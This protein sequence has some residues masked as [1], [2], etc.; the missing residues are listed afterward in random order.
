MRTTYDASTGQLWPL[1]VLFREHGNPEGYVL[2]SLVPIIDAADTWDVFLPESAAVVNGIPMPVAGEIA[3][4]SISAD[5]SLVGS[6]TWY[7]HPIGGVFAEGVVYTAVIRLESVQGRSYQMGLVSQDFFTVDG[8]IA[9]S[10]PTGG[11]IITAVFPRTYG[12]AEI[13]TVTF[14]DRDGSVI[15]VDSVA[16]GE[17]ANPPVIEHVGYLFLGWDVS[18]FM[19]ITSDIT[20]TAQFIQLH[21]VNFHNW[22]NT[23]MDTQMVIHGEAA[24]APAVPIRDAHSDFIGWD[25]DITNITSDVTF[26]AQFAVSEGYAAG[27]IAFRQPATASSVNPHNALAVADRAV[28]GDLTLVEGTYQHASFWQAYG[29]ASNLFHHLTIDLGAELEIARVEIEWGRSHLGGYPSDGMQHYEILLSNVPDGDWHVFA[30]TSNPAVDDRMYAPFYNHV[31]PSD[32][33]ITRGRYIRL[34]VTNIEEVY[35]QW[36]RVAAFRVFE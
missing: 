2:P 30:Q 28:D 25:G 23:M 9:V 1:G 19:H 11:A 34:Q 26:T 21:T 17:F 31:I 13:F 29:G 4:S 36:P 35:T 5:D 20:A 6:V 12:D 16:Y 18:N 27:D 7:P 14:L 33:A 8:A 10:N 22:D 15:Y 32:D 24:V 3:V